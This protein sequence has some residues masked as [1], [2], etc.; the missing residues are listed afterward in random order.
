MSIDSISLYLMS[1]HPRDAARTLQQFEPQELGAYLENLAV[2]VAAD[3]FKFMVPSI[4]V[5]TLKEMSLEKST[6]I[7]MQ[8]GVERGTLLMR[9]MSAGIKQEFISRMSPVFANMARLVLR[10]PEG[11]VGYCMN[12]NVITVDQDLDVEQVMKVIR[13]SAEILKNEIFV[14]DNDQHL[15][16]VVQSKDILIAAPELAIKKLMKT[17]NHIIPA[18]SNI[19]SVKSIVDWQLQDSFP[20]VDH[21]GVF[22]GAL[23]RSTLIESTNT[24]GMHHDADGLTGVA[25]AVAELFWDACSNIIVPEHQ[26][27]DKGAT[28]NGN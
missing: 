17:P 7:I 28:G 15:T 5:E 2:P 19:K 22:V 13:N 14:T 3:I 27:N 8:L 24:E 26:N 16:G 23:Y 1:E 6:K 11:T 18:R 12:P 21:Q 10:Y 9:R 25:L 4:A 20:V